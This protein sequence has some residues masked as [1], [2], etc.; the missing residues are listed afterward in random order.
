MAAG[1]FVGAGTFEVTYSTGPVNCEALAYD[2]L[3]SSFVLATKELTQC[4]LFRVPAP[5]F[6]GVQR[7]QAELIGGLRLPLVTG[8][9]HLARRQAV[10]AGD[11]WSRLLA[12]AQGGVRGSR[13]GREQGSRQSGWQTEG[14]QAALIFERPQSSSGGKYLF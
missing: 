3:S 1:E 5:Q 4:R 10:G 2:P 9:R 14:D 7:V 11:L 6:S 13:P 8:G 12:P